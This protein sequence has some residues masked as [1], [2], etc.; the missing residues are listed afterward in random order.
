MLNVADS[1]GVRG[2]LTHAIDD[3]AKASYLRLGFEVSP[4]APMTLMITLADLRAA[5]GL[6]PER[7]GSGP[8]Q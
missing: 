8:E 6:S 3:A 7:H 1:I 4:L 2:L 5:L